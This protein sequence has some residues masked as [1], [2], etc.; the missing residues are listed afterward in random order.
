M[1]LTKKLFIFCF[2][3][4]ITAGI[5]APEKA[6]SISV[7]EEKDL[8]R[9]FMKYV[10]HNYEFIEDP[11]IVNY[12]ETIGKRILAVVPEQPYPYHFYVIKADVYNA[13]AGP[14]GNI[15]INSGL[16][17]AMESEEELAGILSHE[18]SHSVCRHISQKIEQSKKINIATLAGVVAGTLLGGGGSAAAAQAVTAGSIAAGKSVALANS[19]ENEMQADQL[20]LKYLADAGYS[21]KGLVK[22]LKKM[23]EKQWYTSAQIPT[24]LSTHPGTEDRIGYVGS[25]IDKNEQNPPLN[26]N[27]LCKIAFPGHRAPGFL[28]CLAFSM[29]VHVNRQK[30]R[31]FP[32]LSAGR[33]QKP[34][35]PTLS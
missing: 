2:I 30:S 24:Y 27:V 14:A 35:L 1:R 23:R 15:F 8:S 16:F 11:F 5:A 25:W 6:F 22:I 26:A 19:R 33:D 34:F 13:M 21:A 29:P 17:A 3:S 18:I 20:G 7:K 28:R 9:E 12:V 32:N 31:S 4:L 10:N